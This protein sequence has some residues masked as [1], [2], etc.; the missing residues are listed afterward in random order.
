MG[1]REEH[2][3]PLAECRCLWS[4]ILWGEIVTDS[5]GSFHRSLF[6]LAHIVGSPD[7]CSTMR[8]A[9]KNS[10]RPL[11][12]LNQESER[13]LAHMTRFCYENVPFY[14][15]QFR[16]L[17]LEPSDL[18]RVEDLRKLPALTK[19]TILS[20]WDDFKPVGLERMHYSTRSTGGTTGT[21]FRYRVGNYDRFLS[22]ALL[23]RGWGYAGYELGDRMVFL[24]GASLDVGSKSTLITKAHEFSRNLRKLSSFDMSDADMDA[25]VNVINSFKPRFIR[26]YPSSIHLL[27]DWIEE[28]HRDIHHPDGVFTTSEKLQ[29]NARAKIESVFSCEVFDGYGLNDGGLSAFECQE[30]CGMHV[31]TERGIMEVVD[32]HGDQLEDGEGTILATTLHNYSMPLIRYDTGDIGRIANSECPCGR[33]Q[34]LLTEIVGRSVDILTTPEG[35][36]VHGWFFLYVLWEFGQGIREYQVVQEKLDKILIKVVPRANFDREALDKIAEAIRRK[37]E[38]WIIDFEIVDKIERTASGKHKFIM[39]QLKDQTHR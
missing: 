13:Q 35:M 37:S 16:S 4:A 2:S 18:C 17:R 33:R 12:A 27:A 30:H 26:G 36:K 6:I 5:A 11:R 29:E 31:D 7:F 10:R 23:Y 32:A 39:C 34:R 20:N 19:E 28:N 25:Y 3:G 14:R 24:A 1:Y 38:R 9:M 8:M 15:R 22:G 21:P